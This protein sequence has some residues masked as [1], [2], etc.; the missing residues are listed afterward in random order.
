MRVDRVSV[1][2]V[3]QERVVS[4]RTADRVDCTSVAAGTIPAR[5]SSSRARVL[6][7]A[8]VRRPTL[9]GTTSAVSCS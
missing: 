4:T 3:I 1:S 9:R 8:S 5:N 7:Y 6:R 2:R